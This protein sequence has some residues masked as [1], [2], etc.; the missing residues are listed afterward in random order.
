MSDWNECIEEAKEELGIRGFVSK[1]QWN[2]IINLAKEKYWQGNSFKQLKE[3][4]I[5]IGDGKCLLC[6]STKHLTAHHITYG[7]DEKTVC[8]C[9]KCHNEIIYKIQKSYG[10]ITQLILIYYKEPETIFS[11]F[12]NLANICIDCF[13]IIQAELDKR[14][15]WLKCETCLQHKI[16]NENRLTEHVEY[17][18]CPICKAWKYFS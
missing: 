14:T 8:V 7:I 18:Y 16:L 1:S 15:T 9:K 10:F 12:P 17:T 2:E 4:T 11:K 13:K 5:E 3:E 6:N